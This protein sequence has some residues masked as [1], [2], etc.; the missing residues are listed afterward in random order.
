MKLRN[1]QYILLHHILQTNKLSLGREF[2]TEIFEIRDL[3][4]T[5]FIIH[6]LFNISMHVIS[7]IF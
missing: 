6:Y 3:Y 7:G 4:L 2:R 1:I 5:D